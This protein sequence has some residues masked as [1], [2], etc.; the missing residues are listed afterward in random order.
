MPSLI[1]TFSINTE[2]NEAIFAG[3][4]EPAQALTILQQ[5]VISDAVRRAK[6]ADEQTKEVETGNT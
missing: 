5:L 1:F 2:T 6:E 4:I 3:T